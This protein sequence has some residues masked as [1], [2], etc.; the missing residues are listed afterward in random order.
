MRAPAASPDVPTPLEET[1]LSR[2]SLRARA[3]SPLSA[4]AECKVSAGETTAMHLII[5][6]S[7][8][9]P[10]AEASAAPDKAPKCNC[11]IC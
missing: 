10:A 7:V 3:R 8:S 1:R 9:K 11:V 6:T 4:C 5:K 2:L